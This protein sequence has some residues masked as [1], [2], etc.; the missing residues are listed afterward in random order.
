M[1]VVIGGC[2]RTQ[3]TPPAYGPAPP[4]WTDCDGSLQTVRSENGPSSRLAESLYCKQ[5]PAERGS[6]FCLSCRSI[7]CTLCIVNE[8]ADHRA[9]EMTELIRQQRVDVE[10]LRDVVQQRS[11]ALRKRLAQLEAVRLVTALGCRRH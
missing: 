6:Y 4:P 9:A 10:G 11:D 2:V 5:H 7:V 1:V 3:R 8:H